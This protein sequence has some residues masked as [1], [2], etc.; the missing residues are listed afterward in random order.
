MVFD[1]RSHDS[2]NMTQLDI[3]SLKDKDVTFLI[4]VVLK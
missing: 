1:L 3:M 4:Y 2:N